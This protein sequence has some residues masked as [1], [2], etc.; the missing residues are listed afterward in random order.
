MNWYKK[1][2][3]N[4]NKYTCILTC[5]PS[6]KIKLSNNEIWYHVSDNPN[7]KIDINHSL[8]QGQMGKG[9]YVT[10]EPE[11]WADGNLGER[12]YVYE[13]YGVN[14][15][16]SDERP[17]REELTKWGI[18]NGYLEM[19]IVKRPDG[20]TVLDLHG[21][22]LIRPI[23]TDKLKNIM[24]RDP[25]TGASLHALEHEYLKSK[26]FDGVEAVYSPEGH[27]AVIFSL[28][29][30]KIRRSFNSKQEQLDRKSDINFQMIKLSKLF[31]VTEAINNQVLDKYNK[32]EGEINGLSIRNEIPNMSS[33]E[34][35]IDNFYILPGL[36]EVPLSE[37]SGLTGS[38]YSVQGTKRIFELAQQILNNK[39][40]N[41]LIVVID[42]E[43]PY[44]LEGATRVEALYKLNIFSFPA[45]IVLD[46][47][48]LS[49]KQ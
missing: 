11:I 17:S 44:I 8:R 12:P 47:D 20:S 7:L 37:F 36:Y 26:G 19:G 30:I 13:V 4:N 38:H 33:I 32:V 21:D 27:Q 23:E 34:S 3:L 43:G 6:K 10:K 9:F 46:I 42:K 22:P 1:S 45:K 14:I 40:I 28:E 18:Q 48:S 16:S 31:N 15:A 2:Q 5:M 24:W 49:D 39:E 25:M 29:N 41:P 35:T